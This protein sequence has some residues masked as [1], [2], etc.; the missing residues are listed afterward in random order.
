MRRWCLF[1]S[2]R[3]ESIDQPVMWPFF[4]R[5]ATWKSQRITHSIDNAS[6]EPPINVRSA[7]SLK[8]LSS[9]YPYAEAFDQ[10]RHRGSSPLFTHDIRGPFG[11]HGSRALLEI[12]ARLTFSL[13]E[14]AACCHSNHQPNQRTDALGE[15]RNIAKRKEMGWQGDGA[16][17]Q[18]ELLRSGSQKV[19]GRLSCN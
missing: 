2:A 5:M 16:V 1:S 11:S 14:N 4:P 18:D 13:L 10:Q 8:S 6:L 17:E 12:K 15:K 7:S 3:A 9:N 19:G